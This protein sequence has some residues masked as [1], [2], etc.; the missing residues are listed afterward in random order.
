MVNGLK[1]AAFAAGSQL[2]SAVWNPFDV[3]DALGNICESA[4]DQ[5]SS[6]CSR[7]IPRFY[8]DSTSG[9]CRGMRYTGC[10]GNG[11]NFKTLRGCRRKCETQHNFIND[12]LTIAE[13]DTLGHPAFINSKFLVPEVHLKTSQNTIDCNA[14]KKRG[15]CR[16]AKKRYFWNKDVGECQWF[17][18]GG[19]ESNGN[20]FETMDSCRQHCAMR[21]DTLDETVE[22]IEP[23]TTSEVTAIP[24]PEIELEWPEPSCTDDRKPG[25]CRSAFRHWFYNADKRECESFIWGGCQPNGNNFQSLELCQTA[26]SMQSDTIE[27]IEEPEPTED[28]FPATDC[29]AKISRGMCRGMLQRFAYDSNIGA[30]RE[31]VWGGCDPNGNNFASITE[32]EEQCEVEPKQ[33]EWPETNCSAKVDQGPCRGMIERFAYDSELGECKQFTWGGCAPNGN[34]FGSI[35][36][37]ESKCSQ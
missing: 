33:S 19:C 16:A 5:G 11:N 20:N 36:E 31:F 34:N 13:P 10:G 22:E 1:L 9:K 32:C 3:K 37:C 17:V 30:C 12:I 4:K 15:P 25:P 2:V 18:Y 23:D 28:V 6:I 26:C 24:D 29:T 14:V 21:S 27:H 35:S 8:F 7:R